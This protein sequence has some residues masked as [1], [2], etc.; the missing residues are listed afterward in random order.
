MAYGSMLADTLQ[1]STAGVAPV[2]KDGGSTE[3]GQLCKAWLNYKG[4]ATVSI[5]SSFNV[6]S[7]TVNGTGDYTV[8]FTNAMTDANY[9]PMVTLGNYFTVGQSGGGYSEATRLA[10][11]FRVR[12]LNATQ[13]GT[14]DTESIYI[15]VFR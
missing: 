6:S 4:T 8:N 12:T 3:V 13:S 15:A 7:V 2:F 5:R 10:A 14:Q 9:A 1:S 11:S